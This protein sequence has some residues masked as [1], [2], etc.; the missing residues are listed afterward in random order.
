MAQAEHITTAIRE[1]MSR[2]RPVNS[3]NLVRAAHTEF[4]AALA[5]NAPHPIRSDANWQ[6]LEGRADHPEKQSRRC[7][8]TSVR[9]S[10]K[11]QEMI[12]RQV[13][14]IAATSTAYSNNFRQRC[15]A[16]S[17]MPR[18][19]CGWARIGGLRDDPPI[20]YSVRSSRR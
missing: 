1:L 3:T 15:W 19:R 17:A 6:A 9:S 2:G 20:P 14:S 10:L 4:V 5:G 13:P 11:P 7:T 12:S 16:Q 8:S 18:R